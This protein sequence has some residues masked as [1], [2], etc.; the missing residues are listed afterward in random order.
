MLQRMWYAFFRTGEEKSDVSNQNQRL[1]DRGNKG[2]KTAW[3]S[4][5]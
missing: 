2:R 5:G 3:I 4:A 1:S